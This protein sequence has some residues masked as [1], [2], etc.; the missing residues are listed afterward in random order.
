MHPKRTTNPFAINLI[1]YLLVV[2][3]GIIFCTNWK[4]FSVPSTERSA[5]NRSGFYVKNIISIPA[6]ITTAPANVTT[7]LIKRQTNFSNTNSHISCTYPVI[8]NDPC[9]AITIPGCCLGEPVK[10][11]KPMIGC[12]RRFSSGAT[13]IN[14]F[15]Y[16]VWKLWCLQCYNLWLSAGNSPCVQS[17]SATPLALV[18]TDGTAGRPICAYKK[19]TI[20]SMKELRNTSST[21]S[22]AVVSKYITDKGKCFT[23]RASAY[24]KREKWGRVGIVFLGGT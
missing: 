1:S 13:H 16:I 12:C 20:P 23:H 6:I 2:M 24:K 18:G 9:M 5:W 3:Y 17:W 11:I 7:N 19:T 4:L 8:V 21:R 15:F 22:N 14:R 10:N